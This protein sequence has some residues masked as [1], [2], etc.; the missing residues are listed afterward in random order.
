MAL[1]IKRLFGTYCAPIRLV[2]ASR[3]LDHRDIAFIA[4][5]YTAQ[6]TAHQARH[7]DGGSNGSNLARR[8]AHTHVL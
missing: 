8:A 3:L 5:V 1:N 7:H 4:A 2:H 6:N